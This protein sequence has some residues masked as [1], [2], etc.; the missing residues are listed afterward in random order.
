LNTSCQWPVA[1]FQF[2]AASQNREPDLATGN[3]QRA[4]GNGQRA[5]GNWQ[6]ATDLDFEA[7]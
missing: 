4:T 6:L 5:T 7:M 2:P 1:S 3:W